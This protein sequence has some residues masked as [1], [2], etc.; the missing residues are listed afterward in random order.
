MDAETEAGGMTGTDH[1]AE[2]ARRRRRLIRVISLSIVAAVVTIS[3]KTVAWL[4]TGSVGLLSDALESIINLAAVRPTNAWLAGEVQSKEAKAAT[5]P[6]LL[7]V[8]L[9]ACHRREQRSP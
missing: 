3:M 1:A 6:A 2:A 8:S 4:L 5:I 9:S 7:R